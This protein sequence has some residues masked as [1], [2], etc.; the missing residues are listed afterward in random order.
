M[1]LAYFDCFAGVSGDMI[2]G[3]LVDAGVSLD[4]L[5]AGLAGLNL[6]GFELTASKAVK[7]GITGTQAK[8]TVEESPIH[9]HLPDIEKIIDGSNLPPDV[10]EKSIRVFRTL[11]AAEAEIHNT[12]PDKIHFHEVGALDAIVDIVGSLL[13]LSLLGVERVVASRVHVGSGFVEC[14]HGK[15]PIPSPATVKILEGAPLFSTGIEAELTTP[16]G[17]A[18]L[19]TMVDQFGPMPSMTVEATGYGAGCRDLKIPN[20]LRLIVGRTTD[21]DL[22]T[23][24]VTLIETNIDDMTPEL[25]GYTLERLMDGGALDVWLTPIQMKKGRPATTLSLLADGDT[26]EALVNVVL[27]ETSSLGVRLQTM[28]RRKLSRRMHTVR[29]RFGEVRVKLAMMAGQIRQI[30]PEYDDCAEIARREKIP[31]TTVYD[32][33]RRAA[34]QQV[35][36]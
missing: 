25:L 9:R 3:S 26:V 34:E 14:Q 27:S 30:A 36:E 13:G 18:V 24:Q 28:E 6:D 4:D 31:L 1:K 10:K 22:E 23:D 15:I 29:T 33:V 8:V 16:T 12:T 35:P 11:A 20:L 7:N 19:K 17:A 21:S 32:E 5:R 2:L